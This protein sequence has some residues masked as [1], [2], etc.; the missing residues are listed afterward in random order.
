MLKQLVDEQATIARWAAWT[1]AGVMDEVAKKQQH[2]VR[3]VKVLR[4]PESMG[5]VLGPIKGVSINSS[6]TKEV[7][8]S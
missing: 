6:E 3:R 5:E 2:G 7:V 4:R 8:E 1:F